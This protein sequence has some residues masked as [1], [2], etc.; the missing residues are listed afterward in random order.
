MCG[1][2]LALL[3]FL[4]FVLLGDAAWCSTKFDFEDGALHGWTV[5][6]GDAGPQPVNKDDDRW[7]GNFNK[8]GKWFIGTY[9]NLSDKATVELRSPIFKID[10]NHISLLVGGGNHPA[11][12]YVAL[13]L[14]DND[15]ELFHETGNNR[16][17]M[18]RRLWDVSAYHGQPVYLKIVDKEIGSWGHINMDDIRELTPAEERK[19]A[20]D[21]D[22]KEKA[23]RR[24]YADLMKPTERKIYRGEELKD[25]AFQ[26]GGIGA[27]CIS[28][29]GD[30]ALRQWQIFNKVN[31]GCVVPD[32]Y[33]AVW[34]KAGK[35]APV[36]RILQTEKIGKGIPCVEKTEFIGEF[37]IAHINY[38]D[39]TLPVKVSLDAFSPFIPMDARR[40]AM[41]AIAFIFRVSNPNTGPVAVS[42][43]A[44]LQNAAN[45]DGEGK[46]EGV[47]WEGYG[48]NVNSLVDLKPGQ[49]IKMTNPSIA[50]D[51]MQFGTMTLA[52]LSKGAAAKI[53]WDNLDILWA[54]F[55][56]DG[57][58]DV[59]NNSSP[60]AK[61]RTWNGAL[62][63]PVMLKPGE[64]REV[65]FLISWHFPNFYG[66]SV[67]RDARLKG[68]RLGRMY[69]NWFKNSQ[70]TATYIAR[71]F[72]YLREKT[73]LFRDTF[74]DSSLPYW[75]LDRISSQASTLTSQTT[76]WLEDGT[77]AAF[78]G[79][80]CCPMN[81]EHVYN[82][83][84][85]TSCLFPEL[86]RN[87]RTTDLT[88][89]QDPS[90]F[91]RHRTIL[92]LSLPR[93]SGVFTDGHLGTIL[94]AYR[95]Y[96]H[97]VDRKWLDKM[98]P[99]VKKAMEFV[100]NAWDKN[101]DGVLVHDQWNTYDAAMYG[102]N[103]FIGSLYLAALRA[104]EEMAKIEN[105][106]E[107]AAKCHELFETGGKRLDD[108]LWNGEYWIHI[109]TKEDA[110]KIP[111]GAWI[112]EDWP[113]E[114]IQKD[115][116]RP[117]GEGCHADQLLGQWWANI[118]D[119]GYLFPQERV[120]KT[121]ESILKY[122][123]REDF[124]KVNQAPRSFAGD[125]DRG[126]LVCT[127]PKPDTRPNPFM[128]Y[129]DEVWTG[130]EYEAAALFLREGMV[131]EAY[132]IVKAADDR[133]NG[134]PRPP[135]MRNPW[136]EIECGDHYARAMSSWSVLL[137][138]QGCDYC[139]PEG[140]IGFAP[141]INPANHKSFFTTAKGW[142][143]FEQKR[144]AKTQTETIGMAYGVV[145]LT[146]LYFGI[147]EDKP[148]QITEAKLMVNNR[149]IPAEVAVGKS[150]VRILPVPIIKLSAGD[151]LSVKIK[152]K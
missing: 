73:F 14:A 130:M 114:T 135:I 87:M 126:L 62:A 111:N 67:K 99:R 70:E 35:E 86:E 74:Y 112:L 48:G 55:A 52:A 38:G 23:L 119:L 37:P 50:S 105:D 150:K 145:T 5:V 103:T 147:P 137:E 82:Y 32:S 117:Y 24:W 15:K 58:L 44:S 136:N 61:G 18:S 116:N 127:W 2:R 40:S 72:R 94:K 8:Q 129:S 65:V 66:D 13:C 132:R 144:T 69:N 43:L 39:P 16:E 92:P 34:A 97:S 45:Y 110:A 64:S 77:F 104:A 133:Y 4:G 9:E 27:G 1:R 49:A 41:P 53:Q 11:G 93:E 108:A 83:E 7:S 30:G 120:R 6:S 149:M 142:G 63:V 51:A 118:N 100:W 46:I 25:I 106:T 71:N 60:S 91:T 22:A 128:L 88:V 80:G 102:P 78:E 36:T 140:R 84:Q 3:F 59:S 79:A 146:E 20:E 101:R 56:A 115:Q 68:Y 109:D 134:I 47:K 12:T 98:W 89:Q 95:E 29:C 139:G 143:T 76:L 90:G 107:F 125:G 124:G 113:E 148:S 123:W 75:M 151:T 81:C 131:S 31:A 26:M 28:I 33:F 42:L 121:L 138:A 57:L 141:V 21:K 10:S 17:Q 152:W 96:R 85:T 122:N 54:D 19:I